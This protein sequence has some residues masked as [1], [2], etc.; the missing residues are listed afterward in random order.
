MPALI[1]YEN[2]HDR[3]RLGLGILLIPLILFTAIFRY[4]P[5]IQYTTLQAYIGL[6]ITSYVLL[7]FVIK[8]NNYEINKLLSN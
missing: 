4:R 8:K 5:T 2:H 6:Q 1:H 3:D 7:T